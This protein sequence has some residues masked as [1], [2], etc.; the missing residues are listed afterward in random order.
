M[1]SGLGVQILH[2]ESRVRFWSFDLES[3]LRVRTRSPE[4]KV[5]TW[6]PEYKVWTWSLN[7][8]SRPDFESKVHTW[9]LESRYGVEDPDLESVVRIFSLVTELRNFES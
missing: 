7:L 5:L 1:E 3:G 8:E 9:S 4:S 6:S 2:L